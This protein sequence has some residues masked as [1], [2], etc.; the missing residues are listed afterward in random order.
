MSGFDGLLIHRARIRYFVAPAGRDRYNNA[1]LVHDESL[2][3]VVAARF[4]ELDSAEDLAD[5]DRQTERFMVF[6]RP[7]A[8]P[9]KG[10]DELEWI[11]RG[12][13]VKLDGGPLETY[14]ATSLDHLELGAYR[15]VG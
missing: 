10:T 12:F 15:N 9:L 8:R 3:D 14:D 13:I 2:D 11:D 4:D 7:P 6:M 1:N 5:Q